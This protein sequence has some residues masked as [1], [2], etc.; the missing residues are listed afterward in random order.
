MIALRQLVLATFLTSSAF[1][2]TA[3]RNVILIIGDGMGTAHV[4][5]AKN[6]RAEKFNIGRMPVVGL[7]STRCADRT[8]T[9]SA[10]AATAL[11]T[12]VKT[13]YEMVSV[14][15]A[16]G[17]P[18][19]TVLEVAEKGGR[20]TGIVTTTNFWDATPAAFA[21]HAKHRSEG[22][23]IAKQM[24]RSGAEIII[25]S[26][27]KALQRP[28]AAGMMDFAKAQGYTVAMTR[29]ELDAAGPGPL[30]AVFPEQ[31]RDAENPDA[32]LAMLAKWSIERLN[33]NKSGFFLMI[34]HEGTDSSSHQ[35]N[36]PDLTVSLTAL[37]IT[38]GE[39]LDF[40]A[41]SGDTLVIVT[42]DHET[43][44]LRVSESPRTGRIRLEWATTDHTGS[45]IPVFAFGPG[46]E[47]F[48]GF[49]DN[50]DIG[51]RLLAFV[52]R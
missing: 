13:N 16:T 40:A 36:G 23:D 4:T 26:G 8:V 35:N 30:L 48:G 12:G 24:L 1:A 25:G 46:S 3:P 33:R 9:D 42:G 50:T 32:P 47:Q 28:E 17:A 31:T 10:A 51:K 34:E 29:A 11:A 27:Q 22:V 21:A 41:K 20:T 6:T 43:G 19:A 44:S 39:V 14:D 7:Q 38:V 2:A 49:Y 45:A 15:P 18:L 5:A 52:K 37:D